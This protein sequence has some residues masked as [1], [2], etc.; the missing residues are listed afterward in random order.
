MSTPGGEEI[1][2]AHIEVDMDTAP[3]IRALRRFSVE[4]KSKLNGVS[5]DA[6]SASSGL[7]RIQ[8][9]IAAVGVAAVPSLSTL[10]SVVTALEQIAPAG[11]VAATGVLA[12]GQ[13][14]GVVKLSMIGVGDAVTAAFDTSDKGAEKFD[15][16]LKKLGPEAKKFALT[17]R[18]LAPEFTRFQQSIQDTVFTGFSDKLKSLS[19]SVL[20]VLQT[21]LKATALT[22]NGVA[23]STA[24]AAGQLATNGT[25]GKAMAGAN[26]GLKNLATIP[27][28]V[29]TA[30]GQ[31]AAAGA[32][33]FGRLTDAAAGVATSVSDKLSKAFSSGALEDAVNQAIDV[34][35]GLGTIA[36]NVFGTL[37]NVL[38]AAATGGDGLFAVLTSITQTLQTASGTKGF[39][40]AIGALVQTVG[41]FADTAGPL[42]GQALAVLGPVF[43]TLAGPVQTLIQALGN[44]LTPIIAALGPL[45]EG[46]AQAVGAIVTAFSPLLPII[47]DLIASLL[48][49]LLPILDT[50]TQA[51]TDAAPLIVQLA[52][53][54]VSVLAPA[55][56]ALSSNIFPLLDVFTQLT[57]TLLPV[58]SDLIVQL[59]PTF[60]AFITSISGVQGQLVTLLA[61]LLPAIADL[62]VQLAPSIIQVVTAMVGL[63]TALLPVISLV[64]SLISTALPALTQWIGLLASVAGVLVDVVAGSI[65]NVVIPVIDT[66]VALFQGDF[67]GALSSLGTLFTGIWTQIASVTS[68]VAGLVSKAVD[69]IIG[70]FKYLYNVL[71]GHSIIPDLVNAIVSWFGRL[72]GMAASALSA[73]GGRIVSVAVSAGASMLNAVSGAVDRAVSAFGSLPGKAASALS[74]LAG[75]VRG[76][77]SGA[78]G[79]LVSAGRDL[80][81]GMVAGVRSM[82]GSLASAAKS[83]VGGA[84]SA[85]KHLLGISS[86]SKVFMEIGKDVGRGLIIGLTSTKARIDATAKNLAD[87]ITK[88]FKGQNTRVDDRL[89]R[90][91]ES[92]NKRLDALADQRDALTAR[93]QQA[94]KFAKDLTSTTLGTFSIANITDGNTTV[95]NLKK[96]LRAA[97]ADVLK[98]T[99]D[100]QTL[101]R[102]G[103]RKDLIAQ[104][105]AL[106]P[107][108]GAELANNL[109]N[110]SNSSIKEVNKLQKQLVGSSTSLGKLGADA[111]FDAGKKAG[112]G[113]LTGLKAQRKSIEDLMISIAKSIQKAIKKALGIKSP[114]KVFASL[115]SF[116]AQGFI[117]GLTGRI[118]S[119]ENAASRMSSA[120][121]AA[122]SAA[123]PAAVRSG[124][125][126]ASVLTSGTRQ[127]SVPA[128]RPENIT[129]TLVNRGVIASRTEA[130]DWLQT[131]METLR[132]QRRLPG[133]SA[134]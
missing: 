101:Q 102:K 4:A 72:P 126:V 66:L 110:A 17:V 83:V 70:I 3:A 100:I 18:G 71:V 74:G 40:D 73:L 112:E 91:V 125:S 32:P 6:N 46:A 86:P 109:A 119:L 78:S 89:V 47:G 81:L 29:V 69:T 120:V 49:P 39:Q 33:A 62:F 95:A 45:L 117:D 75:A 13:A 124:N 129:V 115:G 15:E 30:L 41:V 132:K 65:T 2:Q 80:I 55:I 20:P 19:T 23:L 107:E 104:L 99:H 37:K 123:V 44:A 16:A 21:N 68:S 52:D 92:G 128:V 1:G 58:L 131:S 24:T 60:T 42:L 67:S 8:K 11:A 59:M 113:F 90:L 50:I 79:W 27:P 88:A 77:V 31:L 34:L 118:P 98:F 25:L 64:V 7:S 116:T 133:V 10:A 122:G 51:F 48:P 130:L 22:L 134:A 38:G 36:G 111:L 96:Q 85:A 26:T 56:T 93:I 9:I 87:D 54:F 121:T 105:L 14:A 12:I 97:R 82:A 5:R 106:G 84:V 43:T 61:Q 114:S 108:Q 28:Q 57:A 94:Q 35:S 127:A 76:A 53:T 103:L 63:E